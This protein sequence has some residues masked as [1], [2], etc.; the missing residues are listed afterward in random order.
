MAFKSLKCNASLFQYC[1]MSKMGCL[2]FWWSLFISGSHISNLLYWYLFWCFFLSLA[3]PYSKIHVW[4]ET[5]YSSVWPDGYLKSTKFELNQYGLSGFSVIVSL[6]VSSLSFFSSLCLSGGV[7]LGSP[8]VSGGA[9][10]ASFSAE[11]SAHCSSSLP[12]SSYDTQRSDTGDHS[13]YIKPEC[14]QSCSTKLC[15]FV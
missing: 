11:D 6:P 15:I 13:F 3:Y 2:S 12:P 10:R 9:E 7:R 14:R 4:S 5:V 8:S 1:L